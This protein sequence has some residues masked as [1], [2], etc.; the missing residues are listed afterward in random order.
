[1]IRST[2]LNDAGAGPA[3]RRVKSASMRSI[4]PGFG[5]TLG[6]SLLYLSLLVL[7]PLSTLVLKASQLD[8][9]AI[10]NI[11]TAPRALA[12]YRLSFG[13]SFAAAGI[14]AVFG[15]LVAWVLARYTFPLKRIV[16]ALVDLPFALPT[17]VAGITLTTLYAKT[18]WIGALLDKVGIKAAFTP[19]GIGI[20]L[21]F[22][23]LPFVVR[24]MQPVLQDLEVEVEQAAAC[25]GATRFQIFR[26]VILP[27]LW[28]ALLTGFSL[29]FARGLGEYG[30]VVFIAG[31]MPMKTEILPLLIMTRLEQ[32]D[33]AGAT[34]LA[35]V[36]LAAS[37]SIMLVVNLIGLWAARRTGKRRS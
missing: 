1:M 20:A 24:T 17:A 6:F 2:N 27:G 9:S 34:A 33:Y 4:L 7:L 11:I 12:S 5:L 36:M 13:T 29:A 15:F 3:A 8:V 19:L 32:Y 14:N 31:N 18:G 10:W 22:I 23:G 37:F 21:V 28:P 26:R 16:D 25:M 30:S 35:L